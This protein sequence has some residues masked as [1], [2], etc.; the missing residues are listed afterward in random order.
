MNASKMISKDDKRL[1]M[2]DAFIRK[3]QFKKD[4]LIEILHTAQDLF[5]YLDKDI[6]LYISKILNL[7]ASHVYGVATFYNFFKLRKSGTH[8]ITVCLGT[9]CY[10]KGAEEILSV[11]EREFNIKRGETDTNNRLSLFVTRCIGS[12]AMAP[13]VIIDEEVI[14]RASKE[15]VLSKIKSVVGV[16]LIEAG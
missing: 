13:N 2:L 11:I 5:G 15:D 9:A 6:M 10:V 3:Q 12:C 8:V 1:I 16:S 14:G 7:P 4:A